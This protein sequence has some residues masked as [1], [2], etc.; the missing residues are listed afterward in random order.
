MGNRA[1][2]F[3]LFIGDIAALYVSLFLTLVIRYGGGWYEA[4]QDIDGGPFTFIFVA[5]LIIF[6]IAGL[7]DLRRLRDNLEFV[8]TL[9]LTTATAAILSI[10]I[11]YAV[12]LFGIAPKTNLFIFVVIFA[13]IEAIWRRAF[14]RSVS[15]GDAPNKVLLIG[16][17]AANEI[18]KNIRDNTQ[19]GY[20]ISRSSAK[21]RQQVRRKL[22]KK[23]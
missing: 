19:L 7:Y 5:W 1:K 6:F 21:M 17:G 12:P 9:W 20:E 14:N 15:T 16:N 2:I 22:S 23:S 11:F 8:K 13:L 3:L 18:E 4:F 10:L